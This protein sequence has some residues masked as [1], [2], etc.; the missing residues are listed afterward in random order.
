MPAEP[1]K[2]GEML[3]GPIRRRRQRRAQWLRDGERS[4]GRNLAW[5]GA[6]GWLIVTPT[7]LGTF[8]GRWLD[9]HHGSGVFWT[10]SLLSLGVAIGCY[11]AWR[12]MQED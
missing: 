4:L 2:N 8:L 5:I 10:V 6:L 9:R 7:L 3:A 12:Q 11:L 1:P